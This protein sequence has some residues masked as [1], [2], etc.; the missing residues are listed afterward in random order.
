[1]TEPA[2][3]APT[4][5]PTPAEPAAP[6]P[7]AAPAAP[8]PVAAAPPPA[9]AAPPPAA[10][11]AQPAYQAPAQFQP[12]AAES[13]PAP[14][15][16][17]ADLTTRIIAFII[18]AIL[19]GILGA[20]VGIA[21]SAIFLGMIL[22]GGLFIALIVGVLAAIASLVISAAYFTWGWTNPTMRAS[23]GQKALG[24]QVVSA[25]DGATLVR[26]V[27]IRRWLFLYGV[28]ALASA[29]QFALT[30]TSLAG[31]SSLIGLAAFGYSLYLLWT[32]SQSPK[33]QGFHDVQAGTVVIKAAK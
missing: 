14:G 23:L 19:L 26:P 25:A 1:M 12:V 20:F 32:T 9:A 18:D 29:L 31:L 17:Y 24:I 11:P 7:A 6:P 3:G 4:P 16:L 10:A 27:A 22:S 8:P 2:G 33:R 5:P 30:G 15:I 13:G 28:V 21:L